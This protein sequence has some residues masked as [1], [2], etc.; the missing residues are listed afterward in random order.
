MVDNPKNPQANKHKT[1][2]E[3][4]KLMSQ[5]NQ[6]EFQ[7]VRS[8]WDRLG[9]GCFAFGRAWEEKQVEGMNSCKCT[10]FLKADTKEPRSFPRV[11]SKFSGVGQ[12]NTNKCP[13]P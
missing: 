3:S 2:S 9:H 6:T 13:S 12:R 10:E 7:Q 1:C 8:L 5:G 4:K 11:S